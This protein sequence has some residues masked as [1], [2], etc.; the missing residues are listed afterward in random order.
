MSLARRSGGV[1][2]QAE[3]AALAAS[4]G[5]VELSRLGQ[6]HVT[7]GVARRRFE[8]GWGATGAARARVIVDAV[9]DICMTY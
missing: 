3:N 9:S 8:H 2:D 6:R 7:G 1:P 4:D 5:R